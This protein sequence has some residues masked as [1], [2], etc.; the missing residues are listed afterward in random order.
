MLGCCEALNI[1]HSDEIIKKLFILANIDSQS[2]RNINTFLKK[3]KVRVGWSRMATIPTFEIPYAE[4]WSGIRTFISWAF[5]I[6]ILIFFL[7]VYFRNPVKPDPK[8]VDGDITFDNPSITPTPPLDSVATISPEEQFKL[9]KEAELQN[10]WKDQPTKNGNLSNCFNYRLQR[11]DIPNY[12]KVRVGGGTDVAIKVMRL[13][14]DVCVRYVFV[15][16]GS[17]FRITNIPEGQY[18]LKIAYGT[19]WLSKVQN[20]QCLGKFIRNPIYERGEEIL[21]FNL[22]NNYTSTSI[23]NYELAL[24]VISTGTYNSFNSQKI[25]EL[26]FNE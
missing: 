24:D 6:T 10:G 3:R 5:V 16:S 21:N 18:Y 12:L 17:T 26:A 22:V 11:G 19:E 8:V 2:L 25:S 20:Q 1:E 7:V 9:V 14:D 23:R 13:Y 4:I 15:N